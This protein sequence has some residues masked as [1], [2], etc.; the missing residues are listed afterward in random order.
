MLAF[1]FVF[2][3]SM[4]FFLCLHV[5]FVTLFCFVL[6]SPGDPLLQFPAGRHNPPSI[7]FRPHQCVCPWYLKAFCLHYVSYVHKTFIFDPCL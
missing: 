2:L 3:S 6:F 1:G 4:L 5:P 7:S